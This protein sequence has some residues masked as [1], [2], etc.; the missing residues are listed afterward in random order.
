MTRLACVSLR[1]TYAQSRCATVRASRTKSPPGLSAPAIGPEFDAVIEAVGKY[2]RSERSPNGRIGRRG[3]LFFAAL[4]HFTICADILGAVAGQMRQRI[5]RLD[6]VSQHANRRDEF[7]GLHRKLPSVSSVYRPAR[8]SRRFLGQHIGR[9]P[10]MIRYRSSY[11]GGIQTRAGSST[12]SLA[13]ERR[14]PRK[15]F[16]AWINGAQLAFIATV[17]MNF[18]ELFQRVC[19]FGRNS[20][21]FQENVDSPEEHPGIP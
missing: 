8:T 7:D 4:H 13:Q 10:P 3:G 19:D 1:T 2:T 14:N 9:Q 20:S 21:D 15:Y 17:L 18:S 16:R 11:F 5:G 6:D 12:R